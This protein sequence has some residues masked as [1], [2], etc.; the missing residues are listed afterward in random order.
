M[1]PQKTQNCQDNPEEKEQTWRYTLQDSP[2]LQTI[3]Q[4]TVIKTVWNL[5]KNRHIDQC[6]RIESPEINPHT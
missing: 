2:R 3:L 6:N 4:A 1:E 5:H